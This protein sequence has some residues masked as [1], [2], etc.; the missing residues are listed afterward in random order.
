MKITFVT[1]QEI[2]IPGDSLEGIN[3]DGRDLH[4]V[5]LDELNL[6][7]AS[8]VSAHLRGA[9]LYKGIFA[10]CDFSSSNLIVCHCKEANMQYA[11]FQNSVAYSCDFSKADLRFANFQGSTI[12]GA[13]FK[14]A[15]LQG[16]IME[17]L[18][19]E[20][21]IWDGA[22]YDEKTVWPDGFDPEAHGCKSV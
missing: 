16:A 7:N 15:M 22:L 12:N 17:C 19:V 5:I 13:K 11:N 9:F 4:R 1:D 20:E 3:L 2:E 10:H 18:G 6:T 21:A 8:F 14:E